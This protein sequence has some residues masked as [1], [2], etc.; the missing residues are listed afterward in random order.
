MRTS[1]GRLIL[2]TGAN[3]H[4][5]GD[6]INEYFSIP[7][8]AGARGLDDHVHRLLKIR[9]VD[10]DFQQH[11]GDK[12]HIQLVAAIALGVAHL[13]AESFAFDG[14][15]AQDVDFCQRGFHGLKPIGPDHGFDHLHAEAAFLRIP[16]WHIR[17]ARELGFFCLINAHCTKSRRK[18][19]LQSSSGAVALC[20]SKGD[21]RMEWS[22]NLRR[23]GGCRLSKSACR[24]DRVSGPW[25]AESYLPGRAAKLD[26]LRSKPP[27]FRPPAFPLP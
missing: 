18:P 25:S 1:K 15:A 9:L 13:P 14:A 23:C 7:H 22:S 21:A 10:A 17:L 20:L 2:F 26:R 6:G 19:K 27:P 5:L 3:P 11:L 16:Y 8:L 4:H 24:R 12:S